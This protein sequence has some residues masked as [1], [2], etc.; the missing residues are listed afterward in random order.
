MADWLRTSKRFCRFQSKGCLKRET[1]GPI[2]AVSIRYYSRPIVKQNTDTYICSI[3]EE[4]PEIHLI[5]SGCDVITPRE[6][7]CRHNNIGKIMQN[8]LY[9]HNTVT[10]SITLF[11]L[12]QPNQ[13]TESDNIKNYWDKQISLMRL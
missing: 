5:I 11:W 12:Y 4:R 1:E 13:V 8:H 10:K 6:Y 7:I 3:C 2:S 9:L